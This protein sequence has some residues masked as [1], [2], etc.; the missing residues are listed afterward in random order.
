MSYRVGLAALCQKSLAHTERKF[1]LI[2]QTLY[3]LSCSGSLEIT[4]IFMPISL[5][6]YFTIL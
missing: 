1:C 2:S 5:K 4:E 3:G 6:S